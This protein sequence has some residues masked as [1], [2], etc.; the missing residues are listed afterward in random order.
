MNDVRVE[1]FPTP[2][3]RVFILKLWSRTQFI[4]TGLVSSARVC[5]LLLLP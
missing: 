3:S 2:A 1:H 4:N 5:I